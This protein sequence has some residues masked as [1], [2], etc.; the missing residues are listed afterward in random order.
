YIPDGDGG[1]GDDCVGGG[2]D[3][4]SRATLSSYHL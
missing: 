1:S 3:G 4:S 2:G